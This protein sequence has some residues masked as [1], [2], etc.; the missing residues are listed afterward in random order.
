MMDAMNSRDSDIPRPKVRYHHGNLRDALVDATRQ[1]V[2]ERGAE[3]FSLSD[4]CRVAGV[5]TAAPYKHF[6]DKN[7]ILEEI[8]MR[9]F[10]DLSAKLIEA[11]VAKGA[12]TLEGMIAM[13]EAYI[14]FAVEHTAI[15]R[16]MFG[17]N[18]ALKKAESVSDTGRGCF[19]KVIE[20]VGIYCERNA[21][22]GDARVIALELWTFV[23]GASS[24]L[25]DGDYEKVAPGLDVRPL[26]ASVSARLLRAPIKIAPRGPCCD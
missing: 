9:G 23:H 25:V 16:L 24:L 7:E 11:V 21:V 1:L 8:I 13:G 15:F 10:D 26:L 5:T 18:P 12:G 20:Q 6:R 4:A 22:D 3:G 2:V 14:A 19:G 17:Q